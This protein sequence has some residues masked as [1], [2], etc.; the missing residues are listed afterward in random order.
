MKKHTIDTAGDVERLLALLATS[1][2]T[3][4]DHLRE[5]LEAEPDGLAILSRLKFSKAG[6][7]PLDPGRPLNVIEQLNQTFTYKASFQAA[8][9]LL[10]HHPEHAPFCLRLGTSSGTDIES[11]DGVVLAE[12]FAAVTPKNNRKLKADLKRLRDRTARHRYVF[13]LSPTNA[14]MPD[15]FEEAGVSVRRLWP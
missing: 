7:D 14:D 15:D 1:A 10:E 8:A 3:T 9:W 5:L 13:Y 12:V 11:H 2:S 4:R 6:C